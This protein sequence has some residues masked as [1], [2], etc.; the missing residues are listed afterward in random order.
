MPDNDCSNCINFRL[1]CTY[2]EA[3]KVCPVFCTVC[4]I[5]A[6]ALLE[7]GLGWVLSP[8]FGDASLICVALS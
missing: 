1:A 4:L 2:E 8:R 6:H 7:T 3:E 5:G